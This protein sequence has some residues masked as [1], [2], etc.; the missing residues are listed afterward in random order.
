MFHITTQHCNDEIRPG[1]PVF[2]GD[3]KVGTV[4]QSTQDKNQVHSLA[5]ISDDLSKE[6]LLVNGS[7]IKIQS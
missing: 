6:E 4:I 2:L 7:E 5:V 1:T 3:S